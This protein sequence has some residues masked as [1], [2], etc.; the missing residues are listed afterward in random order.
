MA[1]PKLQ[2]T[3]S[4]R[5]DTVRPVSS[6]RKDRSAM[7]GSAA[8][9]SSSPSAIILA[10]GV[11]HRLGRAAPKV[12]LKFGGKTLL[13]RHLAVL[14]AN[15]VQD[16]AITVGHRPDLI[17]AELSRLGA[18]D[19]V[20]LVENPRYREGSVASLAAQ[21]LRLAGG[22]TVLLM[23]GDVL[24]DSRMIARLLEAASENVLLFD[25]VIEPGDEPVKICLRG[26]IITDFAKLPEHP[27]ER[28]GE[29]VGF[30]RFSASMATALAERAMAYV[31]NGRAGSEY[32]AAIRDLIL[33]H[34][35][36][37]GYEDISDLPWTEIDFEADV[38]RARKE[39][40]PRLREIAHA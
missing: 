30:F 28:R 20:T 16:I 19:R 26:D 17:R 33:M 11:G 1:Q 24:Y 12:L 23:D 36:R 37:F 40:L 29:S 39:I 18:L 9:P 38:V 8:A 27:H 32:E 35:D 13:A 4:A 7:H 10:A 25:Q 5:T 15:G 6:L 22:E 2:F 31:E 21:R 3:Q 14:H 34:P